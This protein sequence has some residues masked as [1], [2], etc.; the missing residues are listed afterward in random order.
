MGIRDIYRNNGTPISNAIDRF[1]QAKDAAATK[2]LMPEAMS[3]SPEALNQLMAVNPQ[4]GMMV[5]QKREM[6]AQQQQQAQAQKTSLQI[7]AAKAGGKIDEQG[8]FVAGPSQGGF[9]GNA[10][11]AQAMTLIANA[12]RNPEIKATPEYKLAVAHLSKPQIYQTEQGMVTR[13]GIDI[14]AVFGGEG[15]PSSGN[16]GVV[17]GTEKTAPQ[18][19][20]YNKKFQ[21]FEGVGKAYNQYRNLLDEL[22]P[23]MGAGPLNSKDT[24]RLNSAYTALQMEAKTAAELGA[25]SG[26]DLTLIEKWIPDPSTIS[27]FTKG[28]EGLQGGLDEFAKYMEGKQDTFHKTYEG[29]NVKNKKFS[30]LKKTPA[31]ATGAPKVGTVEDGHRF[32]G[33]DP[34]DPKNWEAE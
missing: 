16:A 32:K 8:N 31:K 12:Q 22:G 26:P 10:M 34:A 17:A 1:F 23:Q 33:G 14:N 3:G 18:Q 25:L 5:Q 4:A 15:K 21:G 29:E 24:T 9:E 20:E 19:A 30:A 28:K 11:D 27:G 2:R 7:D 6:Q 13:P